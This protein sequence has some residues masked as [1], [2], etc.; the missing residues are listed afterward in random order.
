MSS[1]FNDKREFEVIF[2]RHYAPLVG[3]ANKMVGNIDEAADIVQ[4]L[5]VS[6]WDKRDSIIVDG[7]MQSYLL[8]STHNR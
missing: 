4:S 2:R 5:F 1:I 6:I 3:Y 8:R 7:S